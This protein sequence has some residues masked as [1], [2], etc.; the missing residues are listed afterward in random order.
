MSVN[1]FWQ[2]TSLLIMFSAKVFSANNL[3]FRTENYTV[4]SMETYT[5]PVIVNTFTWCLQI[6]PRCPKTRTEMRQRYRIKTES[7]TRNVSECCEGYKMISSRDNETNIK[8]VP[9]CEECL[10]GV[11]IS[12]NECQCNPGYRGN[13]CAASCPPSTWGHQCK[14]KCNCTEGVPCNPVNG[15]CVRPACPP[16]LHGRTCN[17]SCP[18]DRWGP[19]C[20]LSC[21]CVNRRNECH[22]VSGRCSEDHALIE[23]TSRL[24][25]LEVESNE[26]RSIT[27]TERNEESSV[28]EESTERATE[29]SHEDQAR[30]ENPAKATSTEASAASTS[31][32]LK[33]RTQLQEDNSN[34]ARPVIVLV[35]VPER[36]RNL[37]KDRTKFVMKTPFLRHVDDNV[38]LHEMD[39]Q[40]DY[41]KNI[42]KDEVPPAPIPLDVA[43]IVVASIVSLGLT[44]VAVVMVLHMRSK[45]FEAARIS[46]YEEGKIKN[47]ENGNSGRISTIVTTGTLPQTPIRL[48][49]VFTSTPESGTML[50]MFNSESSNNY[51]NGFGTLGHRVSGNLQGFLQDDH[52]DRPPATRILL[53][54]DFE[55]NQEHIYDEI[56]LQSSP[57]CPRRSA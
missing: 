13:D 10:S 3:C 38:N 55:T 18:S 44:S 40:T 46:I 22:S 25:T 37:E 29:A 26:P 47:Q 9:L 33:I 2:L 32:H 52:Y 54:T 51:V 5:E 48:N 12:P 7:K 23:S 39:P 27:V 20:S 30:T 14:E 19:D 31:D 50:T 11:C 8:C 42:H 28:I 49:P 35:S 15:H 45:L 6:P 16:G 1:K 57:L 41:V 21:N 34:T 17:E 4:T 53:Q 24:P 43:L 36:R 56:P